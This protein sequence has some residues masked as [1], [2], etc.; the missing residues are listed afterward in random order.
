MALLLVTNPLIKFSELVNAKRS[1]TNAKLGATWEGVEA[2]DHYPP[3]ISMQDYARG[4]SF[5][6]IF[7]T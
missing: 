5:S 3:K 2:E 4:H 6:R 1:N 7:Q